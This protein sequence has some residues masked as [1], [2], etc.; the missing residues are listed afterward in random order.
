MFSIGIL[1]HRL[2]ADK[3]T[4]LAGVKF[5]ARPHKPKE[6]LFAYNHTPFQKQ[7][8]RAG[9]PLHALPCHA[10][11]SR[12][13]HRADSAHVCPP[14]P[15]P[16]SAGEDRVQVRG[17]RKSRLFRQPLPRRED[18]GCGAPARGESAVGA[19]A[20]GVGGAAGAAS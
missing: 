3:A 9:C 5:E 6:I 19:G 1:C 11:H 4:I 2:T 20:G 13:P 10:S 8:S 16:P 12:S 17:E 18:G 7:F 15:I 14:G